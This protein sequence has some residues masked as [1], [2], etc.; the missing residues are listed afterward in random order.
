MPKRLFPLPLYL[1]SGMGNAQWWI[2]MS[3]ILGRSNPKK[4]HLAILNGRNTS[5]VYAWRYAGPLV[6]HSGLLHR[7][8]SYISF[9]CMKQD[10]SQLYL[11]YLRSR[12]V[13]D[14][15]FSAFCPIKSKELLHTILC[16]SDPSHHLAPKRPTECLQ[17][18]LL[19]CL[20]H[21]QEDR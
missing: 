8:W 15:R 11:T 18:W 14:A 16:L 5:M 2:K 20:P 13:P 3:V 10:H 17:R 9:C 4:L 1:L 19:S 7:R 6:W 12:S 21:T